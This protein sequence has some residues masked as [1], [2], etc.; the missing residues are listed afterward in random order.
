MYST[1]PSEIDSRHNTTNTIDSMYISKYAHII[2]V[3]GTRNN[4][5]QV[6]HN[7]N[8]LRTPTCYRPQET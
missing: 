4:M 7:A 8:Q 6:S 5:I 2:Y 1:S 3:S